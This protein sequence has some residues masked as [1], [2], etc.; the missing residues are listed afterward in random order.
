MELGKGQAGCS[1]AS[2]K[3]SKCPMNPVCPRGA[4][5]FG[6]TGLSDAHF[7][8]GFVTDKAAFVEET[9][10]AGSL[11]FAASVTPGEYKE[12]RD[13]LT[14]FTNEIGASCNGLFGPVCLA[15]GLH[16]WWVPG[17]AAQHR[18]ML[19]EFD[20]VL[21]ETKFV[22]E[23]GLDFSKRRVATR[24]AQLG[25]LQHIAQRCAEVGGKAL[26]IHCVRAYDDALRILRETGCL[27]TCT[28]IFHWFSGSSQ[29]LHEAVKAGCCFSVGQRMLATKKGREYAKAI[30]ADRVLLE[31]DAPEALNPEIVHPAVDFP[32]GQM[33]R[34]L[35]QCAQELAR[36][37]G[38]DSAG[39]AASLRNNWQRLFL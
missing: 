31:T 4:A 29:Q 38:A 34:E 3:D 24:D 11:V 7:H 8:L 12:T 36:V 17:E 21:S 27:E 37:R 32:Y 13:D 22:G 26:S 39:L 19:S 2:P 15:V 20:A 9:R 23:V 16:P 30:P 18:A 14:R 10:R 25:A 5:P 33:E 35:S 6:H 1:A 28:C